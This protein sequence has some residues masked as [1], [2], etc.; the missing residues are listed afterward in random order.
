MTSIKLEGLKTESKLE[1]S[2][3][4]PSKK[5]PDMEME[6]GLYLREPF[7]KLSTFQIPY[8]SL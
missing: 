3:K 7:D 4:F 1:G 2:V 5:Y 8:L 6:Y